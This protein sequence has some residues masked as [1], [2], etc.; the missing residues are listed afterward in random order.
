MTGDQ[1]AP[2][3][4]H[5]IR[6]HPQF[7]HRNNW[8]TLIIF[9]K[10]LKF[11]EQALKLTI[12]DSGI[13]GSPVNIRIRPT[14]HFSTF[15]T[16][17]WLIMN[18]LTWLERNVTLESRARSSSFINFCQQ[19]HCDQKMNNFMLVFKWIRWW[20]K[21]QYDF[22]FEFHERFLISLLSTDAPNKTRPLVPLNKKK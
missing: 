18:I 3:P 16:H 14:I 2:L 22:Y 20:I 5:T 9:V 11:P 7:T 12:L 6:G 10:L 17:W 1:W 21:V 15:Q 8:K 4:R 13:M 19:K